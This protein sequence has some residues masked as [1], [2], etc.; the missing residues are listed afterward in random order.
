MA[1]QFQLDFATLRL[2]WLICGFRAARLPS[3]RYAGR[4]RY[5]FSV[6]NIKP[7]LTRILPGQC[8]GLPGPRTAS[9]VVTSYCVG[10]IVLR[11]GQQRELDKRRGVGGE[12][13]GLPAWCCAHGAAR[14]A[15]EEP[16]FAPGGRFSPMLHKQATK[17]HSHSVGPAKKNIR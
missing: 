7:Q 6:R 17:Y 8:P 4:S 5:E 10:K 14:L 15:V 2:L 11:A 13:G 1:P 9:V 12:G 16:W 3:R